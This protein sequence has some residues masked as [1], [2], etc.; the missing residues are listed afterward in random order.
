MTLAF[1]IKTVLVVSAL[2][3]NWLAAGLLVL[4]R[5]L[6]LPGT[7][8]SPEPDLLLLQVSHWVMW[9][10]TL[11]PRK[12][13]RGPLCGLTQPLAS[14][15]AHSRHTRIIFGQISQL[16][17]ARKMSKEQNLLEIKSACAIVASS[18]QVSE[19]RF[20]HPSDGSLGEKK[21][22]RLSQLIYSLR[23]SVSSLIKRE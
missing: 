2:E 20:M 13:L 18:F 9:D 4:I 16:T 17:K 19:S 11:T 6:L 15:P 8:R 3:L 22:P 14:S 5:G 23:A 21:V 1:F 7:Q 12:P 10:A